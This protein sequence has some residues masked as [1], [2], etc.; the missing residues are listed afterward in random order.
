M[1]FN[2]RFILNVADFA[3]QQGADFS[4]LVA[5]SHLNAEALSNQE[6]KV[7][8]EV[9]NKVLE[10][11]LKM[12][13]DPLL[14]LH[15][16]QHM[17]LSAA[18]LVLQIAQTS[19]TVL[20]AMQYC[21]T[22]SNLACNALPLS[23]HEESDAY[24]VLLQPNPIWQNQC[25]QCVEQT[26]YG[27]L[28]FSIREFQS[29]T[30]SRFLPQKITLAFDVLEHHEAL[31][32][33]FRCA[34]IFNAEE[35]ALYFQKHHFSQKIKTSDYKLLQ[36]LVEHAQR[37]TQELERSQQFHE[38]VQQ[39]IVRLVQPTFPTVQQVAAHLNM[40]VRTFQRKLSREGYSYKGII[41]QIRKDFAVKY[42]HDI[43]LTIAEIAYLLDYADASTFVR[44]FRRWF[45]QTP[46]EYRL[47]L[48]H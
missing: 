32:R 47:G 25:P 43:H 15:I 30:H 46:G 35:T 39:S 8:P 37:R 19:Q 38:K 33:A 41:D 20:E 28:I 6:C 7:T 29:L 23:L 24:R 34:V 2:G 21:C 26:I 4:Q 10:A 11:A 42:L 36:V 45:G 18:G 13:G 48:S 9:Y 17:N 40:S 12:T 44:S 1:Y 22:F 5:L 27:H 31:E 3:A 16:G 14:G